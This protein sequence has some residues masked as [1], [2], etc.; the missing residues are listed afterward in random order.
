MSISS[1]KWFPYV[2]FVVSAIFSFGLGII[3]KDKYFL[4]SISLFLGLVQVYFSS[5]G[6]W[7]EK[8]I[9]IFENLMTATI[10]FFTALYGSVIFTVLVIIPISIFG[11]VNWKKH[12]KE[13]VVQLNKMTWKKSLIIIAIIVFSALFISYLL[14]LI[15]NQKLPILD[16]TSNILNVCGIA[17]LALRYKEGW[18]IWIFCNIV[19]LTTW[20]I[21]L[22][23]GYSENAVMM[24]IICITYIILNIWGFV[25]FIYLRKS[26]EEQV[27]NEIFLKN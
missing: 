23:N 2:Y 3:F 16:S 1:K 20:I 15:P 22:L 19:E 5:K 25:S 10:C 13:K 8:L 6:K 12:E 26:Q 14:S 7:L 27:K 18:I 21:A 24:I 4:G 9:G 11:I 17:L